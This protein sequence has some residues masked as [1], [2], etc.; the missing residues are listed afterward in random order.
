M[1]DSAFR[2]PMFPLGSVL[3]PGA[4]LPLQVF[5]PRY[6][7]MLAELIDGDGRFGV[8]LIERG[9]EVGGGD[10]R[11][12]TAT[13]ARI[14]RVGDIDEERLAVVA[15]GEGRVRVAEWLAD[16][17]YPA[18]MVTPIDEAAPGDEATAALE[19]V[20][21]AF[22]RTRALASEL[23][24][25][26]GRLELELPEDAIEAAWYLCDSAPI[27]Q[28][29]RQRLLEASTVAERMALLE[30]LLNDRSLL[31]EAQLGGYPPT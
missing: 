23:G 24:Y 13:V 28:L 2:L 14:V 1:T 19:R 12:V 15:I 3:F 26:V 5:E 6:L 22:R 17:P 11:F 30:E 18:A 7:Q 8:V 21:V 25:D 20:G 27:E 10:H 31:L 4:V 29:D 16:D 9:S